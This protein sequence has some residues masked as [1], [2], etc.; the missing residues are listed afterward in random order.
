MYKSE[1]CLFERS[2]TIDF[3]QEHIIINENEDVKKVQKE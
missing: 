1:F 3:R 2:K